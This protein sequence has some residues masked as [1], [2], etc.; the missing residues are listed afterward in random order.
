MNPQHDG[1]I[2]GQ[3]VGC[4]QLIQQWSEQ[5]AH[6]V[7][8]GDVGQREVGMLA[9]DLLGGFEE[10]ARVEAENTGGCN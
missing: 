5:H 10:A 7:E 4:D 8:E 9:A 3:I 6:A 2:L 1:P